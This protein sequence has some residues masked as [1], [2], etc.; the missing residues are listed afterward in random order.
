[1]HSSASAANAVHFAES[2]SMLCFGHRDPQGVRKRERESE[3]KMEKGTKNGNGV[4]VREREIYTTHSTTHPPTLHHFPSVSGQNNCNI[5]PK[6]YAASEEV[7]PSLSPTPPKA[8]T[9]PGL[10]PIRQLPLQLSALERDNCSVLQTGGVMYISQGKQ[11][12]SCNIS[13]ERERSE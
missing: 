2:I 5:L 10:A 9:P 6:L 11:F 4:R 7:Q 12:I 3:R 1:M 8:T 13:S